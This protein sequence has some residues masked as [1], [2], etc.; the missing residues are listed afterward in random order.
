MWEMR[1]CCDRMGD[2]LGTPGNGVLVTDEPR[3]LLTYG[4]RLTGRVLVCDM[5]YCPWCGR[6]IRFHRREEEEE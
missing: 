4:D 1:V 3:A 5:D 6:K 2:E